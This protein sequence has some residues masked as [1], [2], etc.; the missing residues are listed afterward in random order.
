MNLKFKLAQINL[1]V[2]NFKYNFNKIKSIIHKACQDR[3]DIVIFPELAIC[4]YPPEDLLFKKTFID[5]NLKFLKKTASLCSNL[6]CI[7]GFVNRKNSVLFNSAAVI[8]N[9]KIIHVYNKVNL[10]NYSVF[11]EKRYFHHGNTISVFDIDNVRFGV[12][13]C[14]DLWVDDSPVFKQSQSWNTDFI[15]NINASPYYSNKRHDRINLLKQVSKKTGNYLFYLNTIGGQDEIVF[16]GNSLIFNEKGKLIQEGKQFEEDIIDIVLNFKKNHVKYKKDPQNIIMIKGFKP[17]NHQKENILL[18]K[19]LISREQEIYNALVL[20]TRDYIIKNNF[21][22][23]I[24]GLS[25]GIDSA[26]TAVIAVDAIGN[27]NVE[28]LFMPSRFSSKHSFQD[29]K[30]ISSNLNIKFNSIS[31]KNIFNAYLKTLNP[32][33]KKLPFNSTEENI[34]ARIRGNILMAFSNKFSYM[35]LTT[36]NK[37]EM[38]TGYATLYGDMAGGFAVLKDV[39]KTLVY[40]LAYYKNKKAGLDLIPKNIITK[41]PSAE[42]RKN[43]KDTDALPDYDILD[44]ILYLYIERHLTYNEIKKLNKFNNNIIKKVINLVD[45][46]EYKRRQA[47]P[48]IKITKLSFGKD[49]RMPI[50]SGYVLK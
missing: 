18:H 11:D 2:G 46:S 40:K 1:F 45:H 44:K 38:S 5:E 24:I 30:K 28:T 7:I 3:T 25:G 20:G 42:L 17:Y 43:Q 26:L 12:G 31:I 39:Y 35:V 47:P 19:N 33:F 21:K 16:D 23:V 22:K 9:K 32:F 6:I 15:I 49:R 29:A 10:P 34:Q 41:E 50:T 27:E 37:S 14:E 36:G 4:G 48:G 8:Y 13:I